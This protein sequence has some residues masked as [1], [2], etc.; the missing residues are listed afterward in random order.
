MVLHALIRFE[1]LGRY[2]PPA[3]IS[4]AGLAAPVWP[5]Q[6]HAHPIFFSRANNE[7]NVS[8]DSDGT[9]VM[10]RT[11]TSFTQIVAFLSEILGPGRLL[12]GCVAYFWR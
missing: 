11:G 5:N 4:G 3:G 9:G 12:I 7:L 8:T 2:F 10:V 1:M 6:Q